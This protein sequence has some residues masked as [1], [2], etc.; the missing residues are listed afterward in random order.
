[1]PSE[2]CDYFRREVRKWIRDT[3]VIRHKD[4]NNPRKAIWYYDLL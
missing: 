2:R 3:Q 1:M 4:N